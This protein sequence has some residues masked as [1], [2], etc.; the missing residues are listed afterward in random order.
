[1]FFLFIARAFPGI[2]SAG[3]WD[4]EYTPMLLGT[5][6]HQQVYY[7]NNWLRPKL[8]VTQCSFY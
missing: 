2:A 5:A 4:Y 7:S 8:A 6:Q 3:G 1:M